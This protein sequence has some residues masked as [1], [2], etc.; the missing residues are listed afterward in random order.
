MDQSLSSVA[1]PLGEESQQLSRPVVFCLRDHLLAQVRG[2]ETSF[3]E[4]PT[5]ST[6]P[7]SPRLL[8]GALIGIDLF[9][10]L[11]S[12]VVFQYGPDTLTCMPQVKDAGLEGNTTEALARPA[13]RSFQCAE[14]NV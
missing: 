12:V 6:F 10:P 9:N 4:K 1:R 14:Q 2:L 8:K 7:G 13:G 11:A 3:K 5:V